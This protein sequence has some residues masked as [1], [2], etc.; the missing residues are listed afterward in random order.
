MDHF[1]KF[2][3]IYCDYSYKLKEEVFLEQKYS[4]KSEISYFNYIIKQ[5]IIEKIYINFK[6]KEQ[7]PSHLLK[8]FGNNK[9]KSEHLNRII[10]KN[11]TLK[12]ILK[13]IENKFSSNNYAHIQILEE[14]D[15]LNQNEFTKKNYK[16]YTDS[17]SKIK[18]TRKEV[19][20]FIK[21]NNVYFGIFFILLW[22]NNKEPHIT[23]VLSDFEDNG[24]SIDK[25]SSMLFKASKSPEQIYDALNA[26][27]GLG[28]AY[29]TKILYFY[30]HAFSE[31]WKDKMYI[32]DQFTSKSMNLLRKSVKNYNINLSDER[33]KIL[34]SNSLV[35]KYSNYK[36]FNDDI[37][38]LSDF[39][40][41]EGNR[42]INE[43]LIE[44]MLFGQNYTSKTLHF[45]SHEL[46]R[47]YVNENYDAE[48][49]G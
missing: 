42:N 16:I 23:N 45:S 8:V 36:K 21:L 47:K 15:D 48:F 18:R 32:M 29:F 2:C 19:I 1:I 38:S 43:E 26:I 13:K 3:E 9:F 39:F 28:P 7:T 12:K 41:N 49:K 10:K 20:N 25:L 6:F 27:K 31:V 35:A 4:S 11:I 30:T 44:V 14:L 40:K 17:V 24:K 37:K 5:K 33:I 22:G 46:W 34:K